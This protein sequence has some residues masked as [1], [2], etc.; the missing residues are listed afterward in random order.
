MRSSIRRFRNDDQ[1][2]GLVEY[3]LLV[4]LVAVA[5]IGLAKG[6]RAS[7]A[8]VT[9]VA[10][11]SLAAASSA[12]PSAPASPAIGDSSGLGGVASGR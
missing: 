5:I 2:Q 3:T 4:A 1:G 8:G 11:S 10:N 6:Y 7:I 12:P 9:S